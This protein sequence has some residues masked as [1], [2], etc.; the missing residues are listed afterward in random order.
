MTVQARYDRSQQELGSIAAH[1][2]GRYPQ[3]PAINC[4]PFMSEEDRLGRALEVLKWNALSEAAQN[5]ASALA[6]FLKAKREASRLPTTSRTVCDS[7]FSD[8]V[9]GSPTLLYPPRE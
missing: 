6:A 4:C 2:R 3:K 8:A 7:E 5:L 1:R 9:G